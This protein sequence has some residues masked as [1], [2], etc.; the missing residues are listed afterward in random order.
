MAYPVTDEQI[1]PMIKLIQSS[2]GK[3]REELLAAALDVLMYLVYSKAKPYKSQSFYDDL[4]QEGRIALIMAINKFDENRG[5]KFFWFA[6][7]YLKIRFKNALKTYI[8]NPREVYKAYNNSLDK[9]EDYYF[10]E[11]PVEKRETREILM[12]EIGKL[13]KKS[14]E[15]LTLKFGL[16]GGQPLTFREI[17]EIRNVSRQYVEQIKST[18]IKKLM[19]KRAVKELHVGGI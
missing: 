18:A 1:I 17:G 2:H 5:N 6:E 16:G 19:K 15:I 7:W 9:G 13:D 10:D 12:N 4:L 11:D 8:F 3:S 14:Q